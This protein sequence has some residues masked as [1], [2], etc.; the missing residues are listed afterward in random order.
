MGYLIPS[1]NFS[2]LF[3]I[4]YFCRWR[5]TKKKTDDL[6]FFIKKSKLLGLLFWAVM[7]I[8]KHKRDINLFVLQLGAA[9][10]VSFAG[11]LFSRFRKNTKRIGPTL[12]PRRPISSG[13]CFCLIASLVLHDLIDLYTFMGLICKEVLLIFRSWLQRLF[14][15]I[16]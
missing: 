14:Q 10:A 4:C 8:T 3:K 5:P 11:F 12:P 1:S 2:L 9:L 15:Q 16:H 7:F 13:L 6:V